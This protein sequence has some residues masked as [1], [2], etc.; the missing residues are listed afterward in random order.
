MIDTA[1]VKQVDDVLNQAIENLSDLCLMSEEFKTA[2]QI[3]IHAVV[4]M[5]EI[6]VELIKACL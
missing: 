5:K 2:L 6:Q 1:N 4:C 3:Q